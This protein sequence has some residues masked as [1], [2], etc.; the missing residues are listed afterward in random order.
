MG[1]MMEALEAMEEALR[2]E[3]T[4]DRGHYMYGVFLNE[5]GRHDE[6]IREYDAETRLNPDFAPAHLNLALTYFFH[7]GN[8][9]LAAFHYRRYLALG[10]EPVPVLEDV[11]NDLEPPETP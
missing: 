4:L 8:P 2:L 1:L 10:G 5:V 9:N 11:M 6:A 3:P 7:G